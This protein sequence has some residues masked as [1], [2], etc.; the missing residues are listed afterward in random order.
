NLVWA[1]NDLAWSG[2]AFGT[3]A[4]A[5]AELARAENETWGNNATHEFISHFQLYLGGTSQP[6]LNRLEVID[7]LLTR[8]DLVFTKLAVAALALIAKDHPTRSGG[9]PDAPFAPEPEW[10]PRT[11]DEF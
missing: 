10:Q 5:L 7:E 1:L 6:Y 9:T 11:K 2:Q 4:L 3:A 8:D